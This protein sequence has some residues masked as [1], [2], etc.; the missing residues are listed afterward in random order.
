MIWFTA[1]EHYGHSNI[2]KYCNRPFENIQQMDEEIIKRHNEVVKKED[3]VIHGGDFTL[4]NKE[5]AGRYIARLNGKHIFIKG[6]HDKWLNN[7]PFIY[8]KKIDENYIVVCHYAMRTWPRSHY[9][10]WQLYGHSHGQLKPIGL[11][12]DIGVDNN[13][14]YPVSLAQIREIIN[15]EEEIK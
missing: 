6:S 8:E 4:A 14:F 1:D 11:Q 12:Y 15:K 10:S 2:I 13:N 9:G 5:I 3:T 7:A